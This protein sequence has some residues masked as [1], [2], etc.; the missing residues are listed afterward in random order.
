MLL[1][2][3]IIFFFFKKIKADTPVLYYVAGVLIQVRGRATQAKYINTSLHQYLHTMGI[4]GLVTKLRLHSGAV[5]WIWMALLQL[6]IIH[7][8]KED[9]R[10]DT[11]F[12]EVRGYQSCYPKRC[13]ENQRGLIHVFDSGCSYKDTLIQK[14]CK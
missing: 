2:T 5:I 1:M 10:M 6:R 3:E 9:G 12:T 13:K 14:E 11:K 7:F 4:I 8:L